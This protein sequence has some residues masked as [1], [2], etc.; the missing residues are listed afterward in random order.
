MISKKIIKQLVPGMPLLLL[1]LLCSGAATALS[2]FLSDKSTG[3]QH[4][5][6][7]LQNTASQIKQTIDLRDEYM[8]PF[9]EIANSDASAA[10]FRFH[11]NNQLNNAVREYSITGN[12]AYTLDR[13]YLLRTDPYADNSANTTVPF[14]VTETTLEL[15]LVSE[16]EIFAVLQSLVPVKDSLSIIESCV[17]KESPVPDNEQTVLMDKAGF[18]LTRILIITALISVN[19]LY[20][21]DDSAS[22][23]G[24][25]MP[26]V[27]LL[28][29][30]LSAG[31]GRLNT[32]VISEKQVRSPSS[33]P[34]PVRAR[35]V[36]V[37]EI[38]ENPVPPTGRILKQRYSG[39][40]AALQSLSQSDIRYNGYFE[41]QSR[42]SVWVNG[43]RM[44][45]PLNDSFE[46]VNKAQGVE[47]KKGRLVFSD[48]KNGVIAFEPGQL[49]PQKLLSRTQAKS[50]ANANALNLKH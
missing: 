22:S 36:P 10:A 41:S 31:A 38:A 1:L 9:N 29:S 49:M 14:Y 33:A 39:R 45:L 16:A 19:L 50:K 5:I 21:Q 40:G 26:N 42:L 15:E 6:S 18:Y 30:S 48:K 8:G 27:K 24:I 35:E 32:T 43:S 2:I 13:R 17:I 47:Y 34:T 12:S 23:T 25:L 11:I 7:G 46:P 37:S 4:A 44:Q 20:A 28:G 3:F